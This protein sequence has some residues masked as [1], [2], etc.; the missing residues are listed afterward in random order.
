MAQFELVLLKGESSISSFPIGADGLIIGRASECDVV[1]PDSMVSRRHARVF[2]DGGTLKVEDLGARNGIVVNGERVS[3]LRIDEGD[4]VTVGTHTFQV[5][6]VSK[7]KAL[8]DTGALITFERAGDMYQKM[9]RVPGGE[10]PV[11]YKAAQL[12]GT[13]FDL[14]ELLR[15]I[16]QLIFEA[17]PAKRGY[18]LTMDSDTSEPVIRAS[19][20]LDSGR[21]NPTLSK[22][23]IDHAVT[24]KN[25][26]LTLNAQ[27]EYSA[28][29]SVVEYGIQSAMC[30]PLC[31]REAVVGAVYIDSGDADVV[32]RNDHLK[33]LTAIGR[34][35]GV[36]VE[37]AR[38]HQDAIERERLVAIGKAT[39]GLGHSIK[40]ILVGIKGGAEF[41][42]LAI[43]TGEWKYLQ[44]GW[45]LIRRSAAR[46]E[47]VVLNLLAFSRDRDPERVPTDLNKVLGE[48]IEGTWSLAERSKVKVDFKPGDVAPMQ[49][50]GH[51]VYLALL[52]LV[53]NA[54][55]ACEE[56][57]GTVTIKTHL[58]DKGKAVIEIKDNGVG[59]AYDAF[60][61][62]FEAFYSTKGS[63]GTGLGLACCK[64]IIQEHGG[65]VAFDSR[66]GKG[67]KFTVSLPV[68]TQVG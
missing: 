22:T 25:A 39:A 48:V 40:N 62:I 31:G 53:T 63:R 51:G 11:L 54:I 33:L 20:P 35:A 16:L 21:G 7:P 42:D 37:N 59:I 23:L 4:E 5:S 43:E 49:L 50:D 10:L 44:K 58:D 65:A 27:E 47:D 67:A 36:A 14:D 6:R 66:P 12:L 29:D 46:I 2:V 61:R 64:K 28:S 26:V 19:L 13:V 60:P 38:L 1:L 55:E 45:P 68:Q 8:S 52:N 56:H 41:I 17:M 18:I 32:F 9:V 30:V 3:R 15:S 24:L 34:V 57:G